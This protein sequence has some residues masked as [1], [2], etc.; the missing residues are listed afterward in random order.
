MKVPPECPGEQTKE[1]KKKLKAE[2]QAAASAVVEA[3]VPMSAPTSNGSAAPILTRQDTMNSLS[4]GFA[5]TANR[6]VSGSQR[7][8]PEPTVDPA[9]SVTSTPSIS[10]SSAGGA[11]RNR[12]L[13][14]PPTA[15]VSPSSEDVSSPTSKRRG[16]MLYA[17]EA[18]DG[19]EVTIS[20]GKEFEIVEPDGK[21]CCTL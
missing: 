13:A 9:P 4:S 14:P 10:A 15:Y 6:S 20:E 3:P 5:A 12:V 2:R 19:T 21:L 7:I 17:Y 1:E 11:R 8:I 16:R 18:R